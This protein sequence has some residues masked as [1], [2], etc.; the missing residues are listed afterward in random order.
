MSIQEPLKISSI[1]LD[2]LIYTKVKYNKNKDQKII[3]IKY[4]DNK[5]NIKNFAFQTPTLLGN[6]IPILSNGF[7]ELEI[8]LIC[9]RKKNH[10]EFI[11]FLNKLDQKILYDANINSNSWFDIVKSQDIYRQRI[12]RDSNTNKDEK[13][14]KLNIIDTN[15]F[16]TILRLDDKYKI[17]IN[18]I[19]EFSWIKMILECY[20]LTISSYGISV[21]IRPIIISFQ[22]RIIDNYNYK[23][24]N[25]SDD[26]SDD[27]ED[28]SNSFVSSNIFINNKE[29][30][31][32]ENKK[33][34]GKIDKDNNDEDNN[35]VDNNDKDNND[36]DNNDENNDV[37]NND[38]NNDVDNNDENNDVDNNDVDNNDVDNN[39]KNNDVDNNDL[40]N[41]DE[42]ND[43]DNNH[44]D[45]N[46]EDNN[47]EDNNHEDN[48]DEDNNDEDN[49]D[50]DNN[51][52]DNNDEDN[53]DEDNNV[54]KNFIINIDNE[55]IDCNEEF[56]EEFDEEFSEN[57][58]L[59]SDS[60]E[61]FSNS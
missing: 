61:L 5:N 37:D 21:F 52:E 36:K 19:P 39:D 42:N 18:N 40:D 58:V 32:L 8:P 31:K 16:K 6:K 55:K 13:F 4:S 10:D 15:N 51:D 2:N 25:D 59:S 53:N 50:E 9:K 47:H 3:Y 41:N 57:N 35:D 27:N 28:F 24:I 46:H 33:K 23:F 45:N 29:M 38:E 49:N 54:D 17:G 43:V 30:N 20:A 7:Y 22:K 60:Q 1:N 48:N 56:N 44:E 26:N 34:K 11:N 12:V 14:I